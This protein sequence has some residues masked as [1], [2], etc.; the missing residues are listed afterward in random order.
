MT[1]SPSLL[2]APALDALLAV[3]AMFLG[4]ALVVQVVQEIYKFLSSSKAKSYH[5]VLRDFFG[6]WIERLYEAG[7]AA[8]LQVR[9]P[10]QFLRSRPTGVLLPLS[11]EDLLQAMDVVAPGW[12]GY[13]LEGL[14][15]EQRLQ[16][17][18]PAAPSPQF[19]EMVGNLRAAAEGAAGGLDARKMLDFLGAWAAEPAVSEAAAGGPDE[20]PAAIDAARLIEAFHREFYPD[21]VRADREF[22]QLTRNFEHAYQRR[23]LRQTFVLGLLVAVVLDMP[24]DEL[25]RRASAMSPEEAI[26]LA[27]TMLEAHDRIAAEDTEGAERTLEDLTGELKRLTSA[28]NPDSAAAATP[29]H[30]RGLVKIGSFFRAADEGAPA[31]RGPLGLLEFLGNCLVTA[32]LISFGAPFWHRLS[33]ALLAVRKP[34]R[35]AA[36]EEA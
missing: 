10:F 32:L 29:L 27:E 24:F 8:H 19:E 2:S 20:T 31:R 22:G 33:E 12:L 4:L 34:A 25:W 16:A 9:G 7:P 35:P 26:G 3:A 14:K 18:R 17:G 13:T 5:K 36:A 1:S 28:L 21:R 6:P 11:K 30:Q 15:S 23:N